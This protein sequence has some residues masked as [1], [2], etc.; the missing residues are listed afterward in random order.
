MSCVMFQV[1]R[2]ND[3]REKVKLEFSISKKE[4]MSLK[5][6]FK[7]EDLGD[8]ICPRPKF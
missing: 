6:I 7:R 4:V 5:Y 8:G 3:E 1:A 2:S